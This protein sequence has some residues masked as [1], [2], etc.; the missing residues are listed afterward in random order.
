MY[1]SIFCFLFAIISCF[2]CL[3][4]SNAIPVHKRFN[5]FVQV[6]YNI[7]GLSPVP[8]PNTIRKI[9]SYSPGFSPSLGLGVIYRV[10]N[11]WSLQ[12][13]IRLDWKSMTIQDSV[14]YFHTLISQNGAEFEGDFTGTNNTK[15]KNLYL[16]LPVSVI[17][18]KRDNWRYNL[19]L[20]VGHLIRPSFTGTVS[21][22]YIRKGNSLGEK[23]QID[24]ATFNFNNRE[25][26]FDMGI[27]GGV[28]KKILK[29]F[30]ATGNLQW[31][32]RPVFPP[33]FKGIGF[34]MY[35]VFFTLGVK[36]EL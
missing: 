4:Q 17:Y 11:E 23:V 1:R 12:A 29:R 18:S 21:N 19:G 28:E 30:Y 16:T 10:H 15:S 25:R 31:G 9:E 6:G 36:M 3:G 5:P 33:S 26:T 7:G 22:G 34:K 13:A 8:L 35:N 32:L 24:I 14:Q 27:Q 2:I 20:F